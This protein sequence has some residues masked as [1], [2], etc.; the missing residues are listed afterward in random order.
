ML[1][2]GECL[3]LNNDDEH[4]KR[5]FDNYEM[6]RKVAKSFEYQYLLNMNYTVIKF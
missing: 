6:L 4:K 2:D 5:T 1:D 3:A